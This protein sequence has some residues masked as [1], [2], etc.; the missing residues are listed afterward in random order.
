V[1][2]EFLLRYMDD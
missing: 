2:T 1:R